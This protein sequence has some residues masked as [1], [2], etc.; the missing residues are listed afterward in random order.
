AN[1]SEVRS[2]EDLVGCFV[3]DSAT[4]QFPSVLKTASWGYDG[5]GQ[6]KVTAESEIESAWSTLDCDHAVVEAFVDFQ[7]ELSVIV[8]RSANGEV[9]CY[10]PIR[11]EHRNHILD[12]SISP[13]GLP[14]ETVQQAKELASNIARSLDVIGVVC[15]EM[16][17]TTGGELVV[18]ELAPRPH[19][20]GH[21]TIEAHATSQFEQQ[22]RAICGLP[23]GSTEQIRPAA[24]LNLLG[25]A[26]SKGQPDFAHVT[27]LPG[28]HLHLYGKTAARVGR[29]MGHV[30]VLGESNEQVAA[31]VGEVRSLLLGDDDEEAGGNASAGHSVSGVM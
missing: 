6:S 15:V 24:M 19:N 8:A 31:T 16:F 22:L 1:F 20:S 2:L 28:A 27:G 29:K 11:N 21:L 9:V 4:H 12:L 18:N 10:E 23:L 5:K 13:A 3:G 25:D 14:N 7:C 17:L 30:T 26:W